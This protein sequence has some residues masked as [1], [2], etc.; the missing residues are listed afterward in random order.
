MKRSFAMR[1]CSMQIMSIMPGFIAQS[2]RLPEDF[3]DFFR[4][5][6]VVADLITRKPPVRIAQMVQCFA[7]C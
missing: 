3:A 2:V 1:V 7:N 4:Q 6:D 5:A